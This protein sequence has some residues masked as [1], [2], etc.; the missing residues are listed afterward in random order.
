[1]VTF[2]AHERDSGAQDIAARAEAILFVKEG[3]AW[4]ALFFSL[5]WLIYHRM[6]IVLTGF[7]ASIVLLAAGV[8]YTGLEDDAAIISTIALSAVFA[9]QANDL[10]RWSLARRG[11]QLVEL[12]NGRDRGECEQKF[13]TSWLASQGAQAQ[14]A[15]KA[16]KH[17]NPAP[18]TPDKNPSGGEE[19]IGLFPEPGK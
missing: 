12:V 14:V 6:W 17:A 13:F 3:F 18:A 5:L 4:L 2:T 19:I 8:V 15:P 10:R 11:Y 16:V 9:L 1:M 7:V